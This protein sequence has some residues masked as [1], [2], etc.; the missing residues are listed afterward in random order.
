[1]NHYE[2][3]VRERIEQ[4]V[5]LGI[6]DI[7]LSKLVAVLADHAPDQWWNGPFM[8]GLLRLQLTQSDTIIGIE[9][10]NHRT[11]KLNP[12]HPGLLGRHDA[13]EYL[14][15]LSK[16]QGYPKH[17]QQFLHQHYHWLDGGLAHAA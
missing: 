5:E 1:M 3:V 8:G 7:Q 13:N 16:A 15:R 2:A 11:S 4:R 12:F 10:L 6:K 17:Q 9:H 14:Q